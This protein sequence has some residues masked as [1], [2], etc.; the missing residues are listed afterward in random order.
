[1][2]RT[3]IMADE[4]LL[5]EAKHLAD[6][7]SKTLSALIQD[8]LREYIA[9]HRPKR[10]ISFIGIGESTGPSLTVEQQDQLLRDGLDPIEGW[11]PDRSELRHL[12][13]A[14]LSNQIRPRS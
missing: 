3:T 14:S 8:A 11:S 6:H 12:E 13:E 10:Q 4:E 5:L 7:E 2:K 9:G 1:M